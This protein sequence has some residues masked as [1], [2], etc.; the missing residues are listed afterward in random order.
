MMSVLVIAEAGVNHNG[1]VGLARDLIDVAAEAK[2]DVVK[3]QTFVP[4][5]VISK[6]APKAEYQMTT[7]DAA[8]SQLEMARKLWFPN[9]NFFMLAEHCETRG[10]QFLSTPFNLSSIDFLAGDMKLKR[11]KLPSG[12]VTNA[13]YLLRAARTGCDIIL[14]T[15]MATLDE[16]RN[17]LAVLAFGFAG[18][19][20]PPAT[21]AF[22]ASYESE[23]GQAALRD[24]VTLLHCT[25][26]YPTPFEAVNLRAM[27]T[28]REAFGLAVGF[29]DH[30]PGINASIAA[31]ARGAVLV[32]KHFTLDKEMDGP[33]HKASLDPSELH[34]LVAALGEV[35]LAMGDGIKA[36]HD[37]EIKN[38][39]IAR[40]SLIAR[41]AIAAGEIFTEDNLTVKRPGTGVSPMLYWDWVGKPAPRS[42]VE[43]EIIT[44]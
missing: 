2:A 5:E 6:N 26:E 12:E 13:P 20:E 11:L 7:T 42:Y 19:D 16:V 44:D 21:S 4:E 41:H 35:D 31:A 3:F 37:V 33:D 27:D 40:K 14:S 36:P 23:A 10:I 15:G 29:S 18:G 17:A 38:M 24:K 32:E 25:T 28:L 22:T 8:E 1:D 30:T 39:P 34:A 9:D 43:D